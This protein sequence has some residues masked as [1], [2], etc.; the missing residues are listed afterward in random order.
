MCRDW[1]GDIQTKMVIKIMH[2]NLTFF[3]LFIYISCLAYLGIKIAIFA[4]NK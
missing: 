1:Y 2:F 4:N 3:Y